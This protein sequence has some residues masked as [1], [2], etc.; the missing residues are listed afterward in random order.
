ME[1][2]SRYIWAF[3][4]S[5]LYNF[6]LFKIA[7]DNCD[8]ANPPVDFEYKKY[9][10]MNWDNWALTTFLA[11]VLVYF[12]PDIVGFINQKMNLDLQIYNIYY[13]GAGPLT[14]VVLFGVFKLLGWKKTWVA[15]VHQ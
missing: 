3:F 11:P 7:K 9:A 14:E 6:I 4:G 12:L 10:K 1:L 5:F 2:L 13:L 15:P 8:N